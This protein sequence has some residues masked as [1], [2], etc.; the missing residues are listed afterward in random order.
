MGYNPGPFPRES[1]S[2]ALYPALSQSRLGRENPGLHSAIWVSLQGSTENLGLGQAVLQWPR[3]QCLLRRQRFDQPYTN[4]GLYAVIAAERFPTLEG[5]Y[6]APSGY[7]E[8][9][10]SGSLA[11]VC[12]HNEV[13]L[14]SH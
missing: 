6:Q 8:R 13:Q 7:R 9:C 12:H 1:L 11:Y 10:R 4:I 5:V 3:R 14:C 2:Y